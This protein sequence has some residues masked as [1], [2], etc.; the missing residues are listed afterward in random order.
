MG[1][2]HLRNYLKLSSM[3]Q[4]A[5]LADLQ[6]D[7]R[8]AGKLAR[9]EVNIVSG[10]AVEL[11]PVRS[12][13]HFRELCADKDLDVI[14]VTLPS[15]LHAEAT[16]LALENGKHVLCEKPMAL[17][18]DDC[19]RMLA[20]RD[21]SGRQLM[22][23][24]VLRFWPAYVQAK[25]IIDSGRFGR[26]LAATMN[27][28]GT[29]PG[30]GWF[31]D[32]ARSGGVLM[33]LHVHD[34]D[35]ALW[36]LGRPDEVFAGGRCVD[37]LPAFVQSRWEYR[38]GPTLQ[39]ESYWDAATPFRAGFKILMERAALLWDMI[40]DNDLCLHTPGGGCEVLTGGHFT[41]SL[42]AEDEYFLRC[43]A[44]HA[45]LDRCRPEDSMKAVEV[46]AQTAGGI[47][48]C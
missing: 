32:A 27:R 47:R 48:P 33:D 8:Q 15:D 14:V 34:I 20:A 44:E 16:V 25:K 12:Y 1:Q 4:V 42:L 9:S 2:A 7:R 5:A 31:T 3:V 19:R 24:H 35:A 38:Q 10:E 22:I 37:G 6:E 46:A 13:C 21:A 30:A 45:P 43:V 29:R 36:L 41:E 28:Y 23:G 26:V 11:G 18:V 39:M 40:G 17:K